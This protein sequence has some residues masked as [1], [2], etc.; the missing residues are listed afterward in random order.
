MSGFDPALSGF[1]GERVHVHVGV[2]ANDDA[3]QILLDK[4]RDHANRPDIDQRRHRHVGADR[5]AGIEKTLRDEAVDRRQDGRVR[6]I[7]LQFFEPCL[8]L[9]ELRLR[10]IDL[11]DRCLVTRL[12]VVVGLLGQQLPI[13]QALVPLQVRLGQVQVRLTLPD[14]GLGHSIRRFGLPNLLLDLSI[15]DLRDDLSVTDLIAELDVD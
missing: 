7:D 5:G 8:R 9:L 15:L 12:G 13:E 1:A 14:R 2:R 11:R 4:V 6:Q 3:L 10:E